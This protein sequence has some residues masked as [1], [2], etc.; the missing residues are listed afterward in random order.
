MYPGAGIIGSV[1]KTINTKSKFS[2]VR[3]R[4]SDS[5]TKRSDPMWAFLDT[6]DPRRTI[7]THYTTT[8]PSAMP[9]GTWADSFGTWA[10]SNVEWGTPYSVVSVN[11]SEAVYDKKRVIHFF[12]K[13]SSLNSQTG[14]AGIA[15]RQSLNFVP[16][17]LFRICATFFKGK[18]TDN[19]MELRLTRV[20][21]I[22]AGP[23]GPE[24]YPN[25]II[26]SETLRN[27][28][29]TKES[30]ISSSSNLYPTGRWHT[31]EG[32]WVE[33]PE[34]QDQVYRLEFTLSGNAEDDIYLNDLW[35]EIAHVR[36]YI[37]LG[38][39]INHDVTALAYRDNCTV[40][41]TEEVTQM[42][43]QVEI[44]GSNSFAGRLDSELQQA[45]RENE[46]FAYS[47]VF[48]PLYLQ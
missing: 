23:E 36:Y 28:E 43:I 10:D 18:K 35:V 20:S 38:G 32:Q 31:H 39:G 45:K 30:I 42:R 6:N 24:Q 27:G 17:A 16:G 12:R 15:V 1:E 19:T 41:T 22:E 29:D 34:G 5:G 7:L 46:S 37:R 47:S 48:T 9:D 4:F 25:G 14:Q 33:I 13:A 11:Y 8:I 44:H 26:H 21:G 3:C 40:G 2:K